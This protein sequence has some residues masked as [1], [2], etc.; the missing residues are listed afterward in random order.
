[1]CEE[2]E[3]IVDIPVVVTSA[4]LKSDYEEIETGDVDVCEESDIIVDI[5]AVVPSAVP[6]SIPDETTTNMDVCENSGSDA[7]LLVN[8]DPFQTTLG[9]A[10]VSSKPTGSCIAIAS[11]W[12]RETG[13]SNSHWIKERYERRR[14]R[15][16]RA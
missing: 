2:S 11:Y 5:P 10:S 1:M 6:V 15:R 13:Y 3:I 14:S 8:F 4:A 9:K 16:Q 7:G 12:T